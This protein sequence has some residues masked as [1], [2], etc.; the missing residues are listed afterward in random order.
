MLTLANVP[1]YPSV[2][3]ARTAAGAVRASIAGKDESRLKE[4]CRDFEAIFIKQ[5]L[6]SMRAT[7]PRTGMIDGGFAGEIYEDML[8]D[9]YAAK[10]ARTAGLGIA[11]MLYR[12]LS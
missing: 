2:G 4:S 1:F 6:S 12:Q 5:M 9:E 8:Y 11:E 7:V 10:M 3:A